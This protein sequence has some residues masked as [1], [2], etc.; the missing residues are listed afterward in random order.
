M[1]SLLSLADRF[2]TFETPFYYYDID[3]LHKTLSEV[4]KNI[5]SSFLKVHY[6][7][8]A[9]V[10][11]RIL[12]EIKTAGL[13][14]DCVSG[15]EVKRAVEMGFDPKEA[16]F[17]ISI[18]STSLGVSAIIIMDQKMIEGLLGLFQGVLIIGLIVALM[19]KGKE[20]IPKE[21]DR[22]VLRRRREDR[23]D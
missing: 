19:I 6:A 17:I 14:A 12:N 20:R 9:N 15:N 13:G 4:Q 10:N 22:R 23:I 3:L 8:K 18:M 11:R 5:D 2:Q 21:G 16:M 7:L 1:S